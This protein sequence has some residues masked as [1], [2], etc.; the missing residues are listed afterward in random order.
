MAARVEVIAG[1]DRGWTFDFACAD[2]RVG[3]EGD[4]HVRLSDPDWPDGSV[5][6][7]LR[8]GGY[9][10]TNCLPHPIFLDGRPVPPSAPRNCYHGATLQPTPNT[11]LR[12]LITSDGAG[13]SSTAGITSNPPSVP[14]PSRVGRTVC[15]FVF[16]LT[17]AAYFFLTRT[18]PF[19]PET[20][21]VHKR[22]LTAQLERLRDDPQAEAVARRTSR[23]FTDAVYE[24]A[25]GHRARAHALYQEARTGLGRLLDRPGLDE[26][27]R[28]QLDDVR[29]FL[30]DR[31]RATGRH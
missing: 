24:E 27:N 19:D 26:E 10:L 14:K 6:I 3:R 11:V 1:P 17:L 16:V 20:A 9:L 7:Q 28:P 31:L 22:T 2:V 21:E 12:F 29:R 25:V 23:T 15:G 8:R 4:P 18:Q 5:R 13:L 30:D